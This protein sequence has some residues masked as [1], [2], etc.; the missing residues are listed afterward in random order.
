M[1]ETL[2]PG[3][4]PSHSQVSAEA[5]WLQRQVVRPGAEQQGEAIGR[6][7]KKLGAR[8]GRYSKRGF[9]Y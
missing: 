5:L 2:S 9:S 8:G 6:G 7:Q 3:S 4:L 1:S